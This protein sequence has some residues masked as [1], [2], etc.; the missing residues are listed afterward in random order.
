MPTQ[1]AVRTPE[2]QSFATL[3]QLREQVPVQTA[4]QPQQDP[5]VRLPAE[6]A[7]VA[8]GPRR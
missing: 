8:V 3:G 4:A 5:A 1:I 6:P 7:E 2:E